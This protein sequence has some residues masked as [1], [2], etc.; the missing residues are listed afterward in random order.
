MRMTGDGKGVFAA[1]WRL[2]WHRWE[3]LCWLAAVNTACGVLG[4]LPAARQLH[5]ILGHTLAGEQLLKGFD[6]AMFYELVR[7]PEAGLLRFTNPSYLMAGLFALLMLLI[8]GG[9]FESYRLDRRLNTGEFFA[10]SGAF[11]WRFVRLAL[12]SLVVFGILG[13]AY[14]D[15]EKLADRLGDKFANDQ[16]GFAIRL[17]GVIGLVLLMLF[18]RLWFDMAKVRAITDGEHR[19]VPNT[20]KSL[21]IARQRVLDLLWLYLRISLVAWIAAL[22]A[23]LIWMRVPPAAIWATFILLELVVLAQLGARMWQVAAL[24]LWYKRY[25]AEFAQ[26]SLEVA[27]PEPPLSLYPETELPPAD[28]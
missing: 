7:V 21:E 22:I 9:V 15:G 16:V 6:I 10:A 3:L 1:G 8:S 28:A 24:T 13:D 25:A 5:R 19:M 4:A 27:E 11:F 26:P 14:L 18:V 20:F 23:F 12:M 2:L 17:V